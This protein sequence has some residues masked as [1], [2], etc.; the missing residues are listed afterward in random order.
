MERA[1]S[2]ILIAA[3]AKKAGTVAKMKQKSAK[4]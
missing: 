2:A 1:T 4:R 3:G